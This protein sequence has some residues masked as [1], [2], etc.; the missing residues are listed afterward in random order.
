MSRF[1]KLSLLF[2]F[3]IS[4]LGLLVLSPAVT[5][6]EEAA[7][8][9]TSEIVQIEM[10]TRD[11][12]GHCIDQKAF[13]AE[14]EEER[15]DFKVN[16]YDL[17]ET[18]NYEL[19]AE[20]AK[21]EGLTMSTPVTLIGSK[22]IQGFAEAETTGKML[23]N[24]IDQAKGNTPH[25]FRSFM[26]AGGSEGSVESVEGGVCEED[27]ETCLIPET[28]EPYFV[29]VP[30]MGSVDVKQYSLPV[31]SIILGFI[32]GFNPCA[33]WVLVTF[34]LIL[35]QIGDRKKMLQIA[36][37]FI[38][39]EAV[40][41]YLILNVW[42]Y[43][44]DFVGLDHI[45][46]PIVGTVAIG[47]GLFFLW[48]WKKSDGT[49][50]VTNS[51]QRAK[52]RNRVQKLAAAE[53]TIAT[54][55]GIIGLALSVNIIEFA[56]SIGIPQA[57][58][59][60][61]DINPLTFLAKQFYMFLYILMYMVDDVIVFGIALYSIEKIGLTQKYSKI[62]NLIGGLLMLVL[63]ALLIFAPDLLVVL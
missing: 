56:C 45:I 31:L 16:Y 38:L 55:I 40:M 10:F 9:P 21:A 60:I 43:T 42:M 35:V 6:A 13:F 41:Y 49:C 4:Q 2:T 11:D 54:I 53:M 62:C 30:F 59:K 15:D 28:Y 27:A 20:F 51:K 46:T 50:K 52:T 1:K 33:M 12:C 24:Y 23:I 48:E 14:L 44:W 22:V 29:K 61:L 47:G 36:G 18:E 37:L 26:D 58:T 34:L 19:F 17:E 8:E 32:D 5:F 39:A 63:G 57:F 3:I 7:T 25:T